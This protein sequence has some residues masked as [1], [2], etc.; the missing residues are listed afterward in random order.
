MGQGRGF[1]P[2]LFHL[3]W[4][5]S[6][7]TP[8][9]GRIPGGRAIVSGDE[10]GGGS[11]SLPVART[12]EGLRGKWKGKCWIPLIPEIP[13]SWW[14]SNKPPFLAD[15]RRVIDLFKA[16]WGRIQTCALALACPLSP[17]SDGPAMT[18]GDA[19]LAHGIHTH[20]AFTEAGLAWPEASGCTWLKVRM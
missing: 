17:T 8:T 9:W 1:F 13:P 2:I 6:T 18:M 3:G 19:Q 14:S 11:T 5:P 7:I 12:P 4:G 10:G 15:K 16:R 20:L